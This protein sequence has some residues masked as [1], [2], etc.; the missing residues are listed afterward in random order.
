M[1]VVA[2]FWVETWR[3]KVERKGR[4]FQEMRNWQEKCKPKASQKGV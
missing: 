4:L 2:V 1:M 3:E